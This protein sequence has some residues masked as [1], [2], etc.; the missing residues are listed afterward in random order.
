MWDKTVYAELGSYRSLSPALQR[1]LGLGED[2]QRLGGNA[3]WRLAWMRDMKSQAFNAGVFGW[4]ARLAP[5]RS[6]AA[7]S[8]RYNDVGIDGSWQYLGTREHLVTVNGSYVRER[9]TEGISGD[10][11]RLNE[12]RLNAS[13]HW[14][15][16][17]GLTG[18]WFSTHGSDPAAR[19]RGTVLQ[20]DWTPWGK[21]SDSAPAW[22]NLVGLRLGAQYTR[23]ASF[24]GESEGASAHNT[25]F[26]FAWTAF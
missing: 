6:V 9:R 20:A 23:Y 26:V 7:P 4:N 13:Y 12:A 17:W 8:D 2:L 22:A 1:K 15:Q 18:G 11:S 10:T 14:Q 25:S 24:G 19:T 16:A 5:D 3:Y 21:D